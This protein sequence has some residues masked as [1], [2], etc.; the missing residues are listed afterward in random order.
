MR[1]LQRN[2]RQEQEQHDDYYAERPLPDEAPEPQPE[3]AE[4]MLA[5]PGPTDLSKRDYLAIL[6]R[7]VKEF[8]RQ[9]ARDPAGTSDKPARPEPA[10][11]PHSRREPASRC[12]ESVSCLPCG[13]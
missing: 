9:V 10:A 5:E 7:A 12:L 4:P 8:S 2:R 6:K 13:P 3:R 1:L 11:H